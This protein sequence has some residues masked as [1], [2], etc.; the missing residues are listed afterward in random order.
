MYSHCMVSGASGSPCCRNTCAMSAVFICPVRQACPLTGPI[1]VDRHP[2]HRNHALEP[3]SISSSRWWLV[4]SWSEHQLE[5][6]IEPS[7]GV[8]L[9]TQRQQ[10]DLGICQIKEPGGFRLSLIL[11]SK[12]RVLHSPYAS[13]IPK[14]SYLSNEP[15]AIRREREIGP[16]QMECANAGQGTRHRGACRS[17]MED[18]NDD[19]RSCTLL[20]VAI[21]VDS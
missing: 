17:E 3:K 6:S 2:E 4:F 12:P 20:L 9:G 10:C 8:I 11:N 21:L 18:S 14:P 13:H 19:S 5:R 1:C 15:G 16:Q 7:D